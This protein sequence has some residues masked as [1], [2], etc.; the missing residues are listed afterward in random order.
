MGGLRSRDV[1][2]S[3]A[4]VSLAAT[5]VFAVLLALEFRARLPNGALFALQGTLLCG[6]RFAIEFYRARR[7]EFGLT[8][9]AIRGIGGSSSRRPRRAHRV[10]RATRGSRAR[11]RARWRHRFEPRFLTAIPPL[12]DYTLLKSVRAVCPRR[13]AESPDFDPEFPATSA[14]GTSSRATARCTCAVGAGAATA[15]C[16]RSTK[17]T[18][19]C[20]NVCSSGPLPTR[21]INPDTQAI[22]PVPFGY[23]EAAR[24]GAPAA[25][26][27]LLA[28]HHDAV[29]S[30]LPGVL[31]EF[32]PATR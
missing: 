25:L 11:G 16:G 26:V 9:T 20:G 12:H 5:V 1:A 10:A 15:R 22:F 19:R 21:S 28:R 4:T 6:S 30:E 14:T 7:L 8:A 29:Q 31:H 2:S 32:E 24:P 27:H 13:F 23:E 18:Q 3:D 17:R